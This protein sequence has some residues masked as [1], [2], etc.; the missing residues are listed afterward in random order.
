MSRLVDALRADPRLQEAVRVARILEL[1]P[2]TVLDEPDEYRRASR[3][4]AAQIVAEDQKK[5]QDQQRKKAA[6]AKS[7]RRR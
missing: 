5:Q 7:R 4:A 1:D 6:E 2:V 3:L